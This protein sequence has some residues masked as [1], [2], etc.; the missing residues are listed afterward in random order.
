MPVNVSAWS[1]SV[2]HELQTMSLRAVAAVHVQVGKEGDASVHHVFGPRNDTGAAAE[3]CQPVAQAA[4]GAFGG[5]GHVFALIMKASRE[6]ALVDDVVVGTEEADAPAFQASEQL[7]KRGGI[8]TAAFPVDRFRDRWPSKS[9]VC[10]PCGQDNATSRPPRGPRP[11]PARVLSRSCRR[12][13]TPTVRPNGRS[14]PTTERQSGTS[15]HD[16]IRA[17][18]RPSSFPEFH[19]RNSGR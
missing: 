7:N 3:A 17:P 13:R 6:F 4:M 19:S 5:D 1:R 9:R 16:R 15:S 18:L 11:S 12:S 14:F 8:T 2:L 10:W